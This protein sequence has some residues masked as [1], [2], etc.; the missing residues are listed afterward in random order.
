MHLSVN[1]SWEL[2]VSYVHTKDA[3]LSMKVLPNFA[4]GLSFMA[5]LA[6]RT[7]EFLHLIESHVLMLQKR[8]CLDAKTLSFSISASL[9]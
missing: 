7:I 8:A 4:A 6:S 5:S 9:S 3:L 1:L 2:L